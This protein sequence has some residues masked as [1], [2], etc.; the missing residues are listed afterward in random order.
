MKILTC[1]KC[2]H[3]DWVDDVVNVEDY[4]P[5]VCVGCDGD[6]I[7]ENGYTVTF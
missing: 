4:I 6:M 7:S 3:R 2:G 5:Y 1:H